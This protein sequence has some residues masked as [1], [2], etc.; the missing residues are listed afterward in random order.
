MGASTS[1]LLRHLHKTSPSPSI[2]DHR[3][4]LSEIFQALT[5]VVPRI[6]NL[7]Y[8]EAIVMSDAI[9]IQTVYIAIGPFFVVES[10]ADNDTKGKKQ[11]VVFNTL[12]S[13]AMRGL[14]LDALSLIRNVCYSSHRV[15][16]RLTNLFRF[17]QIAKTSAR[18]S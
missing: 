9:V 6:N 14:R 18:G 7:I 13:S 10:G 12:G 3:R 17:S 4:Q 1:P 8:A 5:S 11:S 16:Q 2:Q 15:L